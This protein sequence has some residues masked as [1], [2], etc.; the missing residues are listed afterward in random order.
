[1]KASRQAG[2]ILP[3][4]LWIVMVWIAVDIQGTEM[5]APLPATGQ[6]SQQLQIDKGRTAVTQVCVGCHAGI[7]R[8][9][10]IREKSE[11]EWRDTIYSMIGRGAQVLPDEIEPLTEYLVASAGRGRQASPEPSAAAATTSQGPPGAEANAILE[12]R[13]QL[14]HDLELATTRL[15]SEDW[16]TVID[17]MVTFGA[18]V[19]PAERQTLIEYLDGL[20]R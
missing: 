1:M 5:A 7:M 18:S 6:S 17:R 12:R 3:L 15:A 2:N 9:L 8:M 11:D 19:T 14:C 13:C 4:T 20:E 10:E 16:A